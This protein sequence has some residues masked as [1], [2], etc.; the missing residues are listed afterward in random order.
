VRTKTLDKPASVEFYTPA[1]GR[2]I[3]ALMLAVRTDGDPLGVAGAVREAVWSV[4]RGVPVADLQSMRT[5]IGTT[6]A[7]PR[8]LLTLL[9]AFAAT[10]LALGAIGIYGVVAFGVMRRRREIGIRMALG[11]TRGSVI[12]LVLHESAGYALAGLA[13]GLLL[14]FAASGMMKG[15]LF[16]V[17]PTDG[18]TYAMLAGG[19]AVL[20]VLASY[21]PARRAASVNPVDSLRAM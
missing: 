7:R 20:V 1:N 12:S 6:L 19:V 21:A 5:L 9:G 4:D 17:S 13:A 10:G 3:P 8:L 16:E 18:L 2:G 14:A 11:A 15:L